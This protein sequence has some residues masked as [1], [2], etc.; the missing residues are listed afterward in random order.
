MY[1]SFVYIAIEM[2]VMGNN[3]QLY[4]LTNVRVID[5]FPRFDIV[6]RMLYD[7]KLY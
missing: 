7:A 5:D 1:T 6:V 3:L 2:N 4:V